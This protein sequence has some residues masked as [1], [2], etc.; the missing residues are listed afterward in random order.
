[1]TK[2]N[3]DIE[4]RSLEVGKWGN[5]LMAITGVVAAFL[6]HS[7]AL[8]VDGLYSGVNFFSAIVAARISVAV[9]KPADHRYPFGYDAHEALYVT[10]RSLILL[11]I[12]VFAIFGALGKIS[13][14]ATGG[15]VPELVFGPILVYAVAMVTLCTALAIWH[16]RNWQRSGKQSEIL[17]TESR[18]AV[19][20]GVISG[21]AGGG[22]LA[23]SFLR[24]TSLAFIVPVADAIIVLVMCAFIVRQPVM[25][26]LGALREVAGIAAEPATV[27]RVRSA[28][29]D[30]LQDR[31]YTLLEAAVTK[32]G[33]SHLVVAYVKPD[34]PITGTDADALWEEVDEII[35]N[36]ISQ[37]KTELVIAGKTPYKT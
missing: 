26:F 10:F 30:F 17:K 31:P 37:A 16:K 14:Y 1:M 29:N 27:E 18:A 35:L 6:S 36:T 28:L 8:L 22:L 11:G 33:R 20:D 15:E 12:T 25:M 32:M 4:R 7:D 3:Q 5:L 19:V 2:T 9:A 21:G 24:G 34:K 23:A 13:T